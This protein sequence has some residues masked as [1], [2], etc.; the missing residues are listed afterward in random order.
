[1][2]QISRTQVSKTQASKTQFSR[3]W[4]G[5][6]FIQALESFTDP[7]RLGRGRSYARGGKV[8]NFQIDKNQITAQVK[9]SVNPYYG[10]YKEP[11]YNISIE[12]KPISEKNWSNAIA[13]LATKASIISRLLMNEVPENIEESFA[14]FGLHL[15]PHDRKDFKTHCSCP[16]SS[17]PCKHI[18]GVYYQVAAQ[19][20]QDP[21]LLFELRGLTRS[22]L[23]AQLKQS[24][25]GQA[26]ATELDTQAIPLEAS[27]SLYAPL[28]QQPVTESPTVREFWMGKK[29]LPQMSASPDSKDLEPA[30]R[31]SV[32]AIVIK[33]QGDYPPFW[34]KDQ[35]FVAIMEELYDRVTSKNQSLL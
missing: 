33:K 24:P 20:D 7:G 21:Y 26:L 13:H 25:L 30:T 9:G 4:W 6:R 27:P 16:D 18:A 3:T 19:L 14:E 23:Q 8:L 29:R 10:V 1:M 5:A 31:T 22:E 17:N 32:S 12:L 28:Q 15:L 35:S 34:H 2:A 11:T